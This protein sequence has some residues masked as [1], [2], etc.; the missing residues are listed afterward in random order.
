MIPD[1][2]TLILLADG[3]RAR[4]FDEPRRGGPLT[5]RSEWLAGVS[6][7]HLASP[8]PRGGVHDSLGAGSHTTAHAGGHEKAETAFLVELAKHLDSVFAK[9]RADHLIVIAAPK[10]LG[11]LRRQLSAGLKAKLALS[12][13]HDRLSASVDEIHEAVR[14]LRRVNA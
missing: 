5:E 12:E 10:A 8:G 6:V 3:R 2:R 7:P 4:L 9:Q 14:A 13:P 11:V 1:G